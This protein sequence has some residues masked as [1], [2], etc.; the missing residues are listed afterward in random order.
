MDGRG[1]DGNVEME[2]VVVLRRVQRGEHSRK[3]GV[4]GRGDLDEV[5]E[6]R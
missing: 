1:R 2:H 6:A 4:I 3:Q 5:R